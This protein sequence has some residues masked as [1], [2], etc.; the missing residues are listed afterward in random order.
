MQGHNAQ[1]AAVGF[2]E[3]A[4]DQGVGQTLTAEFG[5][6]ENVEEVAA[7]LAGEVEGVGWPVEHKEAGGSNGA[8]IVQRDPAGVFA[9]GDHARDPGLEV[10]AHGVKDGGGRAAHGGEHG[11]PMGS[12]ERGVGG[13]GE[14]GFH[15]GRSIGHADV[16]GG[17]DDRN[18][19]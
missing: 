14:T 1:A 12:D 3:A 13:G 11:A 4:I 8:A 9:F 5:L 15:H 10:A 17:G 2:C 18:R 6:D 16:R 19:T 7:M